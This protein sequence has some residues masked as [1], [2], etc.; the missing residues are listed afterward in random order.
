M[1]T[2][3]GNPFSRR[4]TLLDRVQLWTVQLAKLRRRGFANTT[5]AYEEFYEEFFEDKD[6]EL[7]GTD[8]RTTVRA[9]TVAG[10]LRERLP[11]GSCVLDVGCGLGDVLAGLPAGY[12]LHGMEYARSNIA[13]ARARLGTRAEVREGSIHAIP[14]PEASMDAALCLEVIEHIEDDAGAVREIARVLKPGGFL[15]G[16]VPYTYYWPE[17]KGLMGHFR[18]YSRVTFGRLLAD[19]GLVPE[20]HLPNYPRWHQTYTRRY[21]VIRAQHVLFGRFMG[22]PSLFRFRWPWRARP[23]LERLADRLESLRRRDAAL[24]YASLDTSTFILARKPPA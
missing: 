19:G 12:R 16:A 1:A 20:A 8:P 9:E 5:G 24:D 21:S 11:P 6:V 15:I 14:W 2:H 7:F 18:H 4:P 23:A 22:R 10:A 3:P 13:R 17:Y